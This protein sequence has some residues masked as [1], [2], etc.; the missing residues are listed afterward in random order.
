MI[1]TIGLFLLVLSLLLT[2]LTSACSNVRQFELTTSVEPAEAG[3]ISPGGMYDGGSRVRV[4][5]LPHQ[6]Y[7]FEGW[8]G[9]ATG[10][11]STVTIMMD[12]DKHLTARFVPAGT[13][14]TP[15]TSQTE[16]LHRVTVQMTPE[17]GGTVSPGT[18]D[19]PAGSTLTLTA[20]P[21]PGYSSVWWSGDVSGSTR[22][23]TI[24]VDANKTITAHFEAEATPR[25]EGEYL[26]TTF[27][28]PPGT[29]LITPSGGS[30]P[31][32]TTV[33]IKAYQAEGYRFVSWSG[34]VSG[35]GSSMTVTMN[36][37]MAIVANFEEAGLFTLTTNALN[38]HLEFYPDYAC[39]GD[40]RSPSFSWS[41]VP[42]GTRS[43]VLL[44]DD[45]TAASDYSHWVIYNIPGTARNLAGGLPK[46]AELD[47][48]ILQGRNSAGIYGYSG[49]CPPVY[50]RHTYRFTFYALDNIID[51]PAGAANRQAILNLITGHILRQTQLEGY[52][53]R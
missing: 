20:V 48:G 18:A 29:G 34:S 17:N 15:D 38:P 25:Q 41:G 40:D 26:L 19:Y 50:R 30:Y 31:P 22:S 10:T 14:P 28:N 36:S 46:V 24:I 21:G 47:S 5:A 12:S 1:K 37:D 43:F 2:L 52:F 7:S 44:L 6:G 23:V 4:T 51:L 13:T 39:T 3:S 42:F 27:I 8:S 49:P 11:A 45:V 35:G 32:G 16:T 53:N 9:D 33:E